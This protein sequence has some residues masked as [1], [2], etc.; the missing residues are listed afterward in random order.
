MHLSFGENLRGKEQ[1]GNLSINW[2]MMMMM[3]IIIIVIII[4]TTKYCLRAWIGFIWLRTG[5]S[6]GLL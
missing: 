5:S 1:L 6:S 3:M 2:R 4:T